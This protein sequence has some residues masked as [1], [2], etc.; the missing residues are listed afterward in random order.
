MSLLDR[1]SP[2]SLFGYSTSHLSST[3]SKLYSREYINT[4]LF[5][6]DLTIPWR[7]LWTLTYNYLYKPSRQA[8]LFSDE[9]CIKS[10]V[11]F[12]ELARK[13]FDQSDLSDLY[14]MINS[15][16]YPLLTG[17]LMEH[18]AM[19]VT[20]LPTEAYTEQLVKDL[21][22]SSGILWSSA[23]RRID[24]LNMTLIA[25]LAKSPVGINVNW[26]EWC[27]FLLSILRRHL[28]LPG[29][30]PGPRGLSK[31]NADEKAG[32]RTV[33]SLHS[34]F[35][36]PFAKWIIRTSSV[37]DI[38]EQFNAFIIALDSF[39]HPSNGGSW[40]SELAHLL[41]CLVETMNK[42]QSPYIHTKQHT[43]SILPQ[44]MVDEF[45]RSL[46]PAVSKL[47]FSK[48]ALVSFT[49]Q[50]LIKGMVNLT[51]S[52][53]LPEVLLIVDSSLSSLTE[54]HR[55]TA[56][57]GLLGSICRSLVKE[58]QTAALLGLLPMT[59]AGIDSNDPMKT[60][61][62]LSLMMNSFMVVRFDLKILSYIDAESFVILFLDHCFTY[63]RN[64]TKPTEG[65]EAGVQ[66]MFINT[67]DIFFM[68]LDSGLHHLALEK[69][70][71]FVRSETHLNAAIATGYL[72]GKA[73]SYG[74]PDLYPEYQRAFNDSLQYLF[75]EVVSLL[76]RGVGS[77]ETLSDESC[78]R[79]IVLINC[80]RRSIQFGRSSIVDFSEVFTQL[81]ELSADIKQRTVAN[82]MAKLFRS[83]IKTLTMTQPLDCTS[84]QFGH[85]SE[86][87]LFVLHEI[88]VSWRIPSS[89]DIELSLY[90]AS[91]LVGNI[92]SIVSVRTK[93]VFLRTLLKGFASIKLNFTNFT[94]ICSGK[95]IKLND[96]YN[97]TVNILLS[98]EAS[99]DT[100]EVKKM[101]ISTLGIA[102]Y[103]GGIG[104]SMYSGLSQTI[105]YLKSS[106]SAYKKD[107]A[108]PRYWFVKR[109]YLQHLCRIEKL[110]YPTLTDSEWPS[111]SNLMN[112]LMKYSLDKFTDLQR[113]AQIALGTASYLSPVRTRWLVE[114]WLDAAS[115]SVLDEDALKAVLSVRGQVLFNTIC[116]DWKILDKFVDWI[117]PLN[118]RSD[119]ATIPRIYDMITNLFVETA[120]A[121][122]SP[123]GLSNDTKVDSERAVIRI[124]IFERL[125]KYSENGSWRAKVMSLT[126]LLVF[127]TDYDLIDDRLVDVYL[128]SCASDIQ[129]VRF[130]ALQGVKIAL[131]IWH[132]QHMDSVETSTS[133]LQQTIADWQIGI[134][135]NAN[136]I[137]SPS[138]HHQLGISVNLLT[139]MYMQCILE[140]NNDN[141]KLE[142]RSEVARL[143]QSLTDIVGPS[144]IVTVLDE[145][146]DFTWS[147]GKQ[148]VY[149][150]WISGLLRSILFNSAPLTEDITKI[151]QKTWSN[152]ATDSAKYWN[153]VFGFA[154]RNR[155]SLT[156]YEFLLGC[157]THNRD[158]NTNEVLII[159]MS[160]SGLV[161]SV[162]WSI[163]FA[164]LV[165]TISTIAVENSSLMVRREA[166]LLLR[167]I[168]RASFS[169]PYNGP[170]L[171]IPV[172]SLVTNPKAACELAH[173]IVSEPVLGNGWKVL[174][175]LLPSLLLA[176]KSD[177]IEMQLATKAASK[178]AV[179]L[180]FCPSADTLLATMDKVVSV[181]TESSVHVR[182]LAVSTLG[183]LFSRN[184][185]LFSFDERLSRHYL[186]VLLNRISCDQVDVREAASLC[187]TSFFHALPKHA[188]EMASK[189][190]DNLNLKISNIK[191]LDN[192]P[193]RHGTVLV[194]CSLILSQPYR[195]S[196]WAPSIL[197]LLTK[198]IP[199]R[200]PIT[201][202]V[203]KAFSEFKRTHIDNWA[204]ERLLFSEEELD[205]ISELL[206]SPTYYA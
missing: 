49:S 103:Y 105:K 114:N 142:F 127:M 136:S 83:L 199:D 92:A 21:N 195:L 126:Y 48:N 30:E 56:A 186:D 193:L 62:T 88:K 1:L 156:L 37:G 187:L 81:L 64:M 181:D 153:A 152:S 118:E 95:S 19:L 168:S 113:E 60:I 79:L 178:R 109:A 160:L 42:R 39:F 80:L 137:S 145:Q 14:Q 57:I 100:I 75:T 86:S 47:I 132:M 15:S 36:K 61:A 184:F 128:Q 50:D 167:E 131:H 40:S 200:A 11:R 179:T 192:V 125:V 138:I 12:T 23:S 129:T 112:I 38:L 165:E 55:T 197:L 141:S 104:R 67:W 196:S 173:C 117:V 170:I 54:P 130:T 68:Q 154:T 174:P 98:T 140:E 198:Y 74:A 185:V 46:W 119:I 69:I 162:G 134:R 150:E 202:S 52:F 108:R 189:T 84:E 8:R 91:C 96:L 97:Q 147:V 31:Y 90:L 26:Q 143:V 29:H 176:H 18:T 33:R 190:K 82:L 149:A 106:L 53:M 102:I 9:A 32:S 28:K 78:S 85:D 110:S 122:T 94:S 5:S 180:E 177:D 63:L 175:E 157:L 169:S 22:P 171:E 182:K 71:K 51:P 13:Y 111:I 34:D 164:Q 89:D 148:R 158:F 27:P 194:A 183:T 65:T 24:V 206:V 144:M 139:G 201:T 159:V 16:K 43:D 133:V 45:I 70:I 205:A 124:K 121:F 123:P 101:F 166:V 191:S 58:G 146:L 4:T 35:I 7:P 135:P 163:D 3:N 6:L 44:G 203:R 59:L 41:N 10:V 2:M 17:C 155:R 151:I 172:S 73:L 120:K 77:E 87:K 204:A 20:F 115:A 93:L 116:S 66:A 161:K 25:R 99:L 72:M 76:K 107:R 188:Y